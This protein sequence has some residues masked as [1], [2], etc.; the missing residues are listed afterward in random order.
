MSATGTG[1]RKWFVG[2]LLATSCLTC[3]GV[4]QAQAQA[5]SAAAPA[6]GGEVTEIVVTAQKRTER[7]RDVPMSITAVSAD[8]VKAAAISDTSQ[9]EKLVPGFTFQR[10]AYGVPVF[11]IR[12]IGFYDTT[13][14]TSPAV[15]V[16]AD[17]APLPY[18]A[19]TRGAI[20]DIE[21]VE[22]LKGPQGTLFGQNSTGGLINYIAAKPT[23]TPAAGADVSWGRFNAVNAEAF[24]SGPLSDTLRARLALRTEQQD[25]WQRSVSRSDSL[26]KTRFYNARLLLDWRPTDRAKFELSLSGWKDQSDTQALQFL[27]VAPTN[28][29]GSPPVIQALDAYSA[30]YGRGDRSARSADWDP[31]RSY[32]RD[33]RFYAASLRA[34][35]DLTD[36]LQLTSLTAFSNLDAYVPTDGDGT[37]YG[38]LNNTIRGKL[39]SLSQELRLS[40]DFGP[41]TKVLVGASYQKDLA[42]ENQLNEP[43]TSASITPLGA[44]DF[45]A[46]NN[47][48]SKTGSVFGGVDYKLSDSLTAQVSARYSRQERRFEGCLQDVGDGVAVANFFNFLQGALANRY[49][50]LAAGSCLTLDQATLLPAGMVKDKLDEDNVSWRAGLNWRANEQVMLYAGVTKGYKAGSFPTLPAVY[51]SQLEPVRQ[52]SVLAYEAGFKAS[53]FDRAVQV[54][55]AVFY[56]DYRNKQILGSRF[57]APFGPLP[58]L[59]TLPKSRVAGAE[60]QVNWTPMSGLALNGG[61]TYVASRIK[62]DP[63]A[64]F[65]AFDT[66]GSVT[67]FVGES[68]PNTPKWQLVGS[69]TY[70]WPISASLNSFVGTSVSY[71]S[72]T[73]SILGHTP[74]YTIDG[75]GLL[76]LRAGIERRNGAWRLEAWARNVTDTRYD[77][78]ILHVADTKNQLVGMPATYGIRAS[79]RH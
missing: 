55:G 10:T 12:G 48:R 74:G 31:G 64:P 79:F 30:T 76:D 20:L 58:S 37:S 6:G 60:L 21:R 15:S 29:A 14:G 34:D 49:V 70:T 39:S 59:I 77:L 22:A 19:M 13:L 18:S 47:Q 62:S 38:D 54:D 78:S 32:A 42:K 71:R 3:A 69:A 36:R 45:N 66:Y 16:Y 53:L 63:R 67:S 40:G 72:S 46:I 11:T 35:F 61:V 4:G 73:P 68:F 28:P 33:D 41:R 52:E 56:Y 2:G 65:Q 17:Q 8:A 24:V 51:S 44:Y 50:P 57:I 75:Y 25:P 26:G 27:A 5:G 23:S 1:A 43:R 9:L 7:L